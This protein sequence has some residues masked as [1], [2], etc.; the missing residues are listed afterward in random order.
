[1]T[2]PKVIAS[3]SDILPTNNSYN[4]CD[5]VNPVSFGKSVKVLT[6]EFSTFA[7]RLC[8][9]I[10]TCHWKIELDEILDYRGL[11]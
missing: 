7:I 2:T 4:G 1:M 8:E 11:N 9:I 3:A 6:R 5:F 10:R